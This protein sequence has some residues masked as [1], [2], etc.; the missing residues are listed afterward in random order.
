MKDDQGAAYGW[1][2]N[3]KNQDRANP[4]LFA[5][6]AMVIELLNRDG[7]KYKVDERGVVTKGR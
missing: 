2:N 3:V 5:I 7:D 6:I 4:E 1:Q